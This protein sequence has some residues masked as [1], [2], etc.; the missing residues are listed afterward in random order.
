M[1]TDVITDAADALV[2]VRRWCEEQIDTRGKDPAV[3]NRY[4]TLTPAVYPF[5]ID[6]ERLRNAQ[7]EASAAARIA[8]LEAQLSLFTT[9]IQDLRRENDG[10]RTQV[11]SAERELSDTGSIRRDR[12]MAVIERNAAVAQVRAMKEILGVRG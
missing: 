5:S 6:H 9:K 8:N 12:D 2:A 7:F 4:A 1:I 3:F 11:R 10:L